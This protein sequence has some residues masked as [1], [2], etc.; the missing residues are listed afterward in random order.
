MILIVRGETL[1]LLLFVKS[2]KKS[3]LARL[4]FGKGADKCLQPTH[5]AATIST[6]KSGVTSSPLFWWR[7]SNVFI[8]SN[9]TRK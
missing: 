1:F 6:N 5:K 4:L 3:I 7:V 8:P 2:A 9:E